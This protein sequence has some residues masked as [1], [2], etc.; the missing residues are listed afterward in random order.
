MKFYEDVIEYL[1]IPNIKKLRNDA[2]LINKR[3]MKLL[4]KKIKPKAET[5][6]L[7]KHPV[8]EE[9]RELIKNTPIDQEN[10]SLKWYRLLQRMQLKSLCN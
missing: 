3:R 6:N 10:N 4:E 2:S 8:E 7:I 9:L 1:P 5:E